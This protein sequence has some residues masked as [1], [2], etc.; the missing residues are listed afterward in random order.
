MRHCARFFSPLQVTND[1]HIHGASG[2][3]MRLYKKCNQ[4]T[5]RAHKAAHRPCEALPL[6]PS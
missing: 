6:S 1:E 4:R 3:M 2:S 5:L